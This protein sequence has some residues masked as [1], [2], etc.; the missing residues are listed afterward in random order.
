MKK[1]RDKL[2]IP[3]IIAVGMFGGLLTLV[4]VTAGAVTPKEAACTGA[5]GTWDAGKCTN[6]GTGGSLE[7]VIKTVVQVLLFIIGAVA[8]IMIVIGGLKYVTS[9]GDSAAVTSAKNTILY[10]IVGLIVAMVAYAIVGFVIQQ[11]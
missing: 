9:N 10:S 6:P 5:G 8:V 11:F 4:P 2:F 7:G 3:V 1:L